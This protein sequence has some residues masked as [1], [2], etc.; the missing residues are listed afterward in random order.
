MRSNLPSPVKFEI[1]KL[2]KT[3]KMELNKP[4]NYNN[5]TPQKQ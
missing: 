2:F 3:M 5:L 4:W 1:E